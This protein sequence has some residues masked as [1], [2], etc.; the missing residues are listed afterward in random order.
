MSFKLGRKKGERAIWVQLIRKNEKS[1]EKKNLI[2]TDSVKY[3][4]YVF[5]S[6]KTSSLKRKK[7]QQ[8]VLSTLIV[9]DFKHSEFT[10]RSPRLF[11]VLAYIS[12]RWNIQQLAFLSCFVFELRTQRQAMQD[13]AIP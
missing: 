2:T 1:K 13:M 9:E 10:C 7:S 3:I 8:T 5:P 11:A 12:I 6:R 4:S